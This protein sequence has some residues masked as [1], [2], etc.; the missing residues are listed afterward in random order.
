MCMLFV[1][2][3]MLTLH[4][5]LT[6]SHGPAGACTPVASG[7]QFMYLQYNVYLSIVVGTYTHTCTHTHM[8]V[9]KT[10]LGHPVNIALISSS[11]INL[12]LISLHSI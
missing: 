2:A 12:T 7:L 10:I 4:R 3:L 8:H 9:V 6:S 1:L 11:I 5:V